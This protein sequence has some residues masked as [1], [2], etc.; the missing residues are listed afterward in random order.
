MELDRVMVDGQVP[1]PIAVARFCGHVPANHSA[2][3]FVD[4]VGRAAARVR[5]VKPPEQL[6]AV[7]D[8]VAVKTLSGRETLRLPYG[9]RRLC[10][11]HAHDRARPSTIATPFMAPL[12][13]GARP[14]KPAGRQRIA[15]HP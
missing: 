9:R 11:G 3:V 2:C 13:F 6:P 8:T 12:L 4:P 10:V 15:R 5:A 7:E 14:L 1:E